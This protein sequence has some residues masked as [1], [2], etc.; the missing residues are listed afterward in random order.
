MSQPRNRPRGT[1][2]GGAGNAGHGGNVKLCHPSSARPRRG[3]H[4]GAPAPAAHA[5]RS[6]LPTRRAADQV[7][8]AASPPASLPAR[9]FLPRRRTPELPNRR[10]RQP[11]RRFTPL[12]RAGAQ[13]PTAPAARTG[14]RCRA[15][16]SSHEACGRW[17]FSSCTPLA[18]APGNAGVSP[19]FSF[20]RA[21]PPCG[22]GTSVPKSACDEA[23]LAKTPQRTYLRKMA[24][25]AGGST[26]IGW[27]TRGRRTRG[28]PRLAFRRRPDSSQ[29]EP[30]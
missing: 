17:G 8:L 2:P 30:L 22:R 4:Y 11:T 12:I 14:N 15:R 26:M 9:S 10:P 25:G 5:R 29:P 13:G 21:S 7:V 19:A 18:G 28:P 16:R 23:Y 1:A 27:G 20:S 6:A 24:T 3:P